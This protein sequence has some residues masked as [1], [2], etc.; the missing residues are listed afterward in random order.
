MRA[1]VSYVDGGIFETVY[2]QPSGP[3]IAVNDP[4]VGVLKLEGL[5]S[6][7]QT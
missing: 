3:V 6:S 2:S 1:V 4:V 5:L 7:G